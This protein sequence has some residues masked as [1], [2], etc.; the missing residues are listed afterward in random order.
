MEMLQVLN[1]HESDASEQGCKLKLAL[2]Y[3]SNFVKA[4]LMLVC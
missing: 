4:T 2:S 1:Q 3:K